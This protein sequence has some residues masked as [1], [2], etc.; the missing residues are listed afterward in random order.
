MMVKPNKPLA[1]QKLHFRVKFNSLRFKAKS[2]KSKIDADQ[3]LITNCFVKKDKKLYCPKMLKSLKQVEKTA[4]FK[5]SR[6]EKYGFTSMS[7]K[8]PMRF[9]FKPLKSKKKRVNGPLPQWNKTKID[10]N[11]TSITNYLSNKN[12]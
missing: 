4:N 1:S 12:H 2:N 5:K 6:L 10:A 9:K 3:N 7:A 11:Q 8:L